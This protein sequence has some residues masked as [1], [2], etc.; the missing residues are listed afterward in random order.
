[1]VIEG[2]KGRENNRELP[3]IFDMTEATDESPVDLQQK[4]YQR[5]TAFQKKEDL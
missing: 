5:K 4:I 1:M 2:N 3:I